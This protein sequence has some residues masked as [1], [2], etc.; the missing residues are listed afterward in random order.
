MFCDEVALTCTVVLP[1]SVEFAVGERIV[2]TGAVAP[3]WLNTTTETG[4]LFP[5]FPLGS[6][7]LAERE[8]VPFATVFVF[9]L[10]VYGEMSVV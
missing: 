9:Q 4:A 7:A 6:L 1:E 10:M 8:C 3:P 5:T 2:T